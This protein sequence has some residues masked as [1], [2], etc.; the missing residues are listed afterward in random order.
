MLCNAVYKLGKEVVVLDIEHTHFNGLSTMKILTKDGIT[1]EVEKT[2]IGLTDKDEF[3]QL[4]K[5]VLGTIKVNP[6]HIL[7]NRWSRWL[8]TV[9]NLFKTNGNDQGVWYKSRVFKMF[10][11]LGNTQDTNRSDCWANA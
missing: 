4:K 11:I 2:I 8:M 9:V 7:D 5:D 3:R 1:K 10:F 6:N